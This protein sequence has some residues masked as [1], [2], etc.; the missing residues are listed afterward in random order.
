MLFPSIPTIQHIQGTKTQYGNPGGAYTTGSNYSGY[1]D[2][3][4]KQLGLEGNQSLGSMM[5]SLTDLLISRGRIDP[6]SRIATQEAIAQR[7]S[8][9]ERGIVGN[10]AR[11]GLVNAGLS[12]AAVGA[13]RATTGRDVV[14]ESIK[15]AAEEEDRKR[16][17]LSLIMDALVNPSLSLAEIQETINSINQG[18]KDAKKAQDQNEILGIIGAGLSLAG[19]FCWVAREVLG[20]D[21]SEW[22]DVRYWLV[23]GP[24]EELANRYAQQ[25]P[26]LADKVR[27]DPKLR[28]EL[29]P[30]FKRLARQGRMLQERD[31]Q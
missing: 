29:K 17:N 30:V 3:M 14:F 2:K 19:L 4:A 18:K 23:N 7:G 25:G 13:Q 21:N 5:N 15:A 8:A 20:T 1:T 26:A 9:A 16:A 11:G 6:R 28:E 12:G 31:K 22:L 10:F 27:V 24:D